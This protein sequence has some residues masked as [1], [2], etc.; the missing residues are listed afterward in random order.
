MRVYEHDASF[1]FVQGYHRTHV[2]QDWRAGL[3][4]AKLHDGNLVV[5]ACRVVTPLKSAN[6]FCV[7][8]MNVLGMPVPELTAKLKSTKFVNRLFCRI[9]RI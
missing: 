4:L 5:W 1:A 2:I 8:V 6:V 9:H 3:A 7:Y